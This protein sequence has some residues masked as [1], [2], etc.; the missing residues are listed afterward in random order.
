M[1]QLLKEGYRVRGTA[2]SAKVAS[3]QE[4]FSSQPGGD[5][6]E[7]VGIDDITS[8]DFTK[9]LVGVSGV[10]HLASPLVGK[11]PPADM[12][13]AAVN[14]SLNII[15]QAVESG[16][17][18]FSV[19]SSIGAVWD[20]NNLKPLYSDQDWNPITKER[21]LAGTDPLGT[22][23]GTKT[24]AERAI[25]DFVAER[26]DINITVLNPPFF[27]GPLAPG[28]RVPPGDKQALSTDEFIYNLLSPQNK[29]DTPASGFVDVRDVAIGLVKGQKTQG[30]HRIIFGG[31]W[32]TYEEAIDYI[33]EIHPE[34]KHRLATANPTIH[35]KSRLDIS[36]AELVLNLKPRPW[37]ESVHDAVEDLLKLEKSWIAQGT[38]VKSAST[39]H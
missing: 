23:S 29:V 18:N 30:R 7:I 3:V 16:I 13:D 35:K 25:W 27:I 37:K 31:Q 38:E 21:I 17:K 12:L 28:F 34:L 15:K 32:F 1:D 2:R 33:A 20:R 4:A 6:V 36:K 8:D 24:F 22:Y 5:R 26:P 14:G 10:L 39:Y 19:I 9:A 11:L